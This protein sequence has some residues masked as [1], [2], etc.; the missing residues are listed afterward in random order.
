MLTK[1]KMSVKFFWG[2]I[3]CILI[4]S[5][6]G[7]PKP[8]SAES[9]LF[10]SETG[11]AGAACTDNDPCSLQR[12]MDIAI[13][14]DYIY[15][16]AGT[17]YPATLPSDQVLLLNKA[18]AIYGGWDGT[19]GWVP[20]L[21]PNPSLTILD[22]EHTRRGITA[23]NFTST[24]VL[25][26]LT[27]RNGNAT[28]KNA[29]C[30]ASNPAGCGGGIF[31]VGVPIIIEHCIIEDNVAATS[32][33]GTAIIGYGGGIYAQLNPA[34]GMVV[35]DNIIRRN[36]ASTAVAIGPVGDD[37]YGQGGG[38]YATG[39]TYFESMTISGNEI[40][41]NNATS[42]S[43]PGLGAGLAIINSDGIIGNN[44][45]HDNNSN[46]RANGSGLYTDSYTI[47]SENRI[48]NNPGGIALS[49][50]NNH[51]S[52]I[53]NII[54]NPLSSYGVNI[55]LNSGGYPHFM[56]NN[57]I[58]HHTFANVQ[59][60]NGSMEFYQNTLDGGYYGIYL[61]TDATVNIKN[62]II[63][64]HSGAG[65]YKASGGGTSN[66]ANADYT[67]FHG[68]TADSLDTNTNPIS[69]DP[70]YVDAA[71]GDYHIQSSSAARDKAPIILYQYNF[72]FENDPRPA[73]LGD[74]AYDVGADEFVW[75][76]FFLPLIIRP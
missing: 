19:S 18:V 16:G 64:H 3:I 2:A 61:N 74:Y 4:A 70:L 24:A 71:G 63:S 13:A 60:S 53:S 49:I 27:I 48:I 40:S 65:I 20:P 52:L 57:V 33:E 12:A 38:I 75:L 59:I 15:V 45:I 55:L 10:V 69:G 17:Y 5:L 34:Y 29:L 35:Q 41:E 8:V 31:I 68:N 14:G 73:G 46:L 66:V 32:S 26:G 9:I 25:S 37:Y 42:S 36:S 67:L 51:S 72:D 30:S 54:D 76:K 44:Y 1:L 39:S 23:Y 43:L 56:L 28:N 7:T 58:A 11:T 21:D 62:S 47:I 22:G 6:G 50:Y